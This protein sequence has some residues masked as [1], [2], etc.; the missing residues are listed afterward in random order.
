MGIWINNTFLDEHGVTVYSEDGKRLMSFN[1]DGCDILANGGEEDL[2]NKKLGNDFERVFCE[3]LAEHGFWVH[4]M[5]QK[6]D[7]Q[8]ADVIAVRNRKAYLIDCKVCSNWSF[9]L[10]R[11][12]SNQSSSMDLWDSCGNGCG[13]FALLLPDEKI[14]M[15]PFPMIRSYTKVGFKSMD[16][17]KIQVYSIEL[18]DWCDYVD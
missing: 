7:G 14:Y 17:F 5:A 18:E 8:P 10:S 4:N 11:V 2:S 1:K 15:M 16:Q 3:K 6:R 12:E 9:D 13:Y